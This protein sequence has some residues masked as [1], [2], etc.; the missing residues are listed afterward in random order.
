MSFLT[1]YW[2]A[3]RLLGSEARLAVWVAVAGAVL[4][5][6]QFAEPILFGRVVD[7]LSKGETALHL[8]GWWA[9]FGFLSV[10][11]GVFVALQADRLAHRRRLAA[12]RRFFEHVVALPAAYHSDAQSGRL[13]GIMLKGSDTLFGIWLSAFREQITATVSLIVLLP[14]AF[15]MNWRMALLLMAL[16]I[17]YVALNALVM[18]KTH[19]GQAQATEYHVA[20]AGQVGDV[21]TNVAIVQSF[22]RLQE[23][24]KALREIMGKLLSVQIPVLTWWALASILTK[25]ASTLTIVAIF[26]LG[27]WLHGRGET[28]VGEIVSFVGFATLLIGRLDQ[29]TSFVTRLFFDAPAMR[30]F[31]EVLDETGDLPE[32]PNAPDLVVSKAHVRFEGVSFRYA[33]GPAGV[34]GL[35][36]EALPG[37][38]IAIVGPTGS[39]K[40]TTLALLQR[41]RDP[42]A[43]RILIDGQDIKD[44]KLDSLR[45]QIA[46]V[47]QDAG[48]FDRSIAENLRIGKTDATEADIREAAAMAEATGFIKDKPGGFDARC[49]ER[50][51]ALSGGERQRLAI[52]RAIL[53][54]A[55]ILILDEATS[56][57]D[58]E[59]EAKV[60]LA[61]D[62]VRQGRTTFIIAHRLS[63]VRTAD[64]ILFLEAGRIVERG[65]YDELVKLN[66]RFADLIA[67]GELN[68]AVEEPET[69]KA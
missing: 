21:I 54:N 17:G 57:L 45:R 44:V 10:A 32:K 20:L 69:L 7:A 38:T 63:T 6:L 47:F 34:E 58:T 68:E 12:M 33:G 15:A 4:A 53:K 5:I 46:V 36:I 9:L 41:V 42:Q 8:V 48:L 51:R 67:A 52:A 28:T 37:Q 35:D 50:G 40:S 30:Q 3:M 25:A 18:R 19:V 64:Q 62:R 39:G 2:R 24:A 14:V 16:M 1:V 65:T 23:E 55:P 11:A 49:G 26:A 29:M 56:A 61:L 60:K 27:A 22:S 59:T 13:I 31:F 66:G 43:G